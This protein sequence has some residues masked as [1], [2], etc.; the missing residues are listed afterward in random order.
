MPNTAIKVSYLTKVYKLY[1]KPVDRL[2]ESLHPLKKKY[3]KDFYALNDVSFEIKKGETVGIIGKN[4]AGKSTLLKIITGVLTPSSGHVHVNGRIASLLELG[5]G[6]NPEYTGIE[7]IYLQGTLMG[8]SHSEMEAKIDE[9]LAF[10]DIGDFVHQPVK[11]Y[12]SGMY[13]RLAFS[14]AINVEPDILIVDEALSVGD[15]YFQ[16]KCMDKIISMQKNNITFLFVSHSIAQIKK[17]CK[18][19]IFI[20]NGKLI[21]HGESLEVCDLYLNQSSIITEKEKQEAIAKAEGTNGKV[22]QPISSEDVVNFFRIDLDFEKKYTERSGGGEFQ[23]VALDIYNDKNQM[24]HEIITYDTIR[25]VASC[26]T[27]S[28]VERGLVPGLLC[29][30]QNGNDMFACNLNYYD[31]T[32]DTMKSGGQFIIEWIFQFPLLSGVNGMYTFSIGA[33]PEAFSSYFYDR[34]FNAIVLKVNNP[35]GL[36]LVGGLVKVDYKVGTYNV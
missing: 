1:D 12:S 36:E 4:G 14:V 18:K 13:A 11:S 26:V 5:A 15:M 17:V 29:R 6:F 16:Q 20:Q 30:D 9:I 25:I 34:I 28:T 35:E 2:K 24:V 33:K 22:L 7:N 32:L 31:I 3:H 27:T 21:A 23:F 8:Y 10:A 19:A